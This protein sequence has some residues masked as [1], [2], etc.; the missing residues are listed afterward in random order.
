MSD[1]NFDHRVEKIEKM[2][3]DFSKDNELLET[4]NTEIEKN[5]CEI[6]KEITEGFDEIKTVLSGLKEKLKIS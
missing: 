6:K 1:S 5:I 3:A 2:L 4:Q